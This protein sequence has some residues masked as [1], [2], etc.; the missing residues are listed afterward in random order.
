MVAKEASCSIDPIWSN[1][2]QISCRPGWQLVGRFTKD[3]MMFHVVPLRS[4]RVNILTH[5]V[6]EH[7]VVSNTNYKQKDRKRTKG[8][9]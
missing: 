5:T 8:K 7:I 9:K 6:A 3:N 4:K 2:V 1:R